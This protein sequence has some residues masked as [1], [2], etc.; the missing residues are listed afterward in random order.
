MA[1]VR[2][3][4]EAGKKGTLVEACKQLEAA[5]I[6]WSGV[7]QDVSHRA[8]NRTTLTNYIGVGLDHENEPITTSSSGNGNGRVS[9]ETKK[10]RRQ[11]VVMMGPDRSQQFLVNSQTTDRIVSDYHGSEQLPPIP[12]EYHLGSLFSSINESINELAGSRLSDQNTS[13]KQHDYDNDNSDPLR[14]PANETEYSS[15]STFSQ[16]SSRSSITSRIYPFSTLP[17]SDVRSFEM[18][19][20][21]QMEPEEVENSLARPD[22]CATN[23]TPRLMPVLPNLTASC[24]QDLCWSNSSTYTLSHNANTNTILNIS[25][26]ASQNNNDPVP[27]AAPP[28][29]FKDQ[30]NGAGSPPCTSP[31]HA[32]TNVNTSVLC[33]EI[34]ILNKT[35]QRLQQRLE[36]Q[37]QTEQALLLSLIERDVRLERLEEAVNV[38]ARAKKFLD[39]E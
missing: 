4:L 21:V 15:Y 27:S 32:S 13:P 31:Q 33:Q 12:Q 7:P 1:K 22:Q 8:F 39:N 16:R 10:L 14:S 9:P 17:K 38:I 24:K 25:D 18:C 23:S 28:T 29:N 34:E 20:A 3:N 37:E 30:H 36:S 2:L 11:T 6:D 19:D 26:E 35:N 5:V